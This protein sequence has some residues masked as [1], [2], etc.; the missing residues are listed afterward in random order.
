MTS[1]PDRHRRGLQEVSGVFVC[2]LKSVI[3]G[4]R[5]RKTTSP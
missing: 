4:T 3:G 1:L 2:P 5:R